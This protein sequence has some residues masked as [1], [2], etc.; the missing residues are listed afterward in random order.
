MARKIKVI[1]ES[2]AKNWQAIHGEHCVYFD[3]VDAESYYLFLKQLEQALEL[4]DDKDK[5][6]GMISYKEIVETQSSTMNF[7]E[8][9][10]E[11]E[12]RWQSGFEII[13][14]NVPRY[15][16]FS[17]KPYFLEESNLISS[18]KRGLA[19]NSFF[20][21][22]EQSSIKWFTLNIKDEYLTNIISR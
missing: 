14:R 19:E 5:V 9:F 18:I 4:E 10:F 11:K 8:I 17:H 7:D 12:I 2:I 21:A 16:R 13:Y 15:F 6:F 1:V 20:L 3:F 22:E